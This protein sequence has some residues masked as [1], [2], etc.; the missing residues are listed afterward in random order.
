MEEE[1]DG[2]AEIASAAE[3]FLQEK[4]MALLK[5]KKAAEA[6]VDTED[7]MV[8]RQQSAPPSVSGTWS[9]TD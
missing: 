6:K 2:D 8:R 9:A 1:G 4:M 5:A 7:E 3:G